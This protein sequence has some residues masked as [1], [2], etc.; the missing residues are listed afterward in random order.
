MLRPED[1]RF[2]RGRLSEQVTVERLEALRLA[3]IQNRPSNAGHVGVRYMATPSGWVSVSHAGG[4]AGGKLGQF[5]ITKVRPQLAAPS[6]SLACWVTWG[7]VMPG[8]EPS[9]IFDPIVLSNGANYI[10]LKMNF[11]NETEL[12]SVVIE[13]GSAFPSQPA[14]DDDT[15]TPP[16]HGYFPLGV[17]S[18][19]GGK[20]TSILNTGVGSVGYS[21]SQE[22]IR[23]E[24]P[25]SE[26]PGGLV[27]VRRFIFYRL[28]P[29]S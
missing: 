27:F 11:T 20:I 9:N 12:V 15:G 26:D 1:F 19:S 18:V 5:V 25:T 24:L 21:V 23:V 2:E 4:R 7:I 3:C 17:V 14:P 28:Q 13:R 16:D 6:E 29:Q 22:N 8:I 10:W